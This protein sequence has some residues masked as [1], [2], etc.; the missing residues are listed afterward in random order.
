MGRSA[1]TI[2]ALSLICRWAAVAERLEVQP[3]VVEFERGGLE[4]GC[5]RV[6]DAADEFRNREVEGD[7]LCPEN[8]GLRRG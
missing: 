1:N 3:G 2:Q 8:V 4:P 6:Q 5:G 7:R